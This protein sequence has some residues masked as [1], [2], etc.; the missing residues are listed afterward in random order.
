MK[1]NFKHI[2]I[3][4]LIL[5]SLAVSCT[6]DRIDGDGNGLAPTTEVNAD[7]TI[8]ET[9]S[10]HYNLKF[11]GTNYIFSRWKIG[12]DPYF[13]GKS[14]ENIFIPDAGQYVIEHQAI[15]QG[16]LIAG[17]SKQTITV[18]KTDPK[19]GNLVKGGKFANADDWAKWTNNSPGSKAVWTFTAGQA[20]LNSSGDGAGIY[21][22][23]DV[24][25][26]TEYNIDMIAKS[27]TGAENTWF[28]VYVG[29]D[30]PTLGQDYNGD[31]TQYRA[32]NTWAG[33]GKNPF[34]GKISVVGEVD[35]A[36]V[37]KATKTGTVYLGI[38]GGGNMKGGISITAVEFRGIN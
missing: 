34:E 36:G 26:G 33:S 11:S 38:R 29:Y 1:N 19:A 20:T 12:D 14:E 18:S 17:S 37:F 23:I 31:G 2:L 6:P 22:A 3:S 35:K 8:V 10:N 7:F 25:A 30:K 9:S 15:G 27:T 4:G 13:S 16:G 21:Q 32:I 28:E 5:G 24:V